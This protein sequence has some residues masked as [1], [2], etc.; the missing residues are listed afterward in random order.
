VARHDRL[1]QK[2]ST[3]LGAAEAGITLV[4]ARKM[5]ATDT[6]FGF[7]VLALS[8]GLNLTFSHLRER[9]RL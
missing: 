9:F 1:K 5:S 7:D 8:L 3:C 6:H 2:S 4:N